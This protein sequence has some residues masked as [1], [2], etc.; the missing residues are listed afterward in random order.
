MK[1]T[2][3]SIF[4]ILFIL[5]ITACNKSSDNK[6]VTPPTT[7]LLVGKW[8]YKSDEVKIYSKGQQTGG[9][10]YTYTDGE[11]I[12][13]NA[14]GTGRND[15]T[16]FTYKVVDETLTVNYSA[17]TFGGQ[18]YDA[19]SENSHLDEL[20]D[21]KLTLFYDNTTQDGNGLLTGNSV[22]EYLIK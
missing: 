19:V 16:T 2:I 4:S 20:S 17:Y 5:L 10:P 8:Q 18:V 13:F 22:L 9:G 3:T 14:D 1:K 12:Q 11:Y 6:P 7:D 21:H 15:K